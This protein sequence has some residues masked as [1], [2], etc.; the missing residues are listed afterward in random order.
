MKKLFASLTILSIF[1]LISS[2]KKSSSTSYSVT[3]NVSGTSVGFNA[4][5]Y[6]VVALTASTPPGKT[7]IIQAIANPMTGQSILL[8]VSNS[9]GSAP[10]VTGTTYVDTA[11]DWDVEGE[12]I[13]DQS[14][15]YIA[16]AAFAFDASTAGVTVANH[17][18]ITFTSIDSTAV[19]GTFSGDFYFGGDPNGA[20]K[21]IT[22]GSFDVLIHR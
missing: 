22:N 18:K 21:S 13:V 3:A 12:Y 15:I 9:A 11:S 6:A 7:I 10:I 5:A 20:I 8:S 2:C 1:L 4:A 14:S 17:L 19:K 16:G